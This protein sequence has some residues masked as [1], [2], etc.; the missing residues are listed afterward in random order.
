MEK[1]VITGGHKLKGTIKVSGAKNAALPLL[2][3]TILNDKPVQ[4]N[5]VPHLVDITTTLKILRHMGLSVQE[6]G[7]TIVV[8]GKTV[9]T[10][11]APYDLVRTMRASVLALGPLV[12]RF[13]QGKVSLPGGCSIG[14]RPV[15]LHL[16]AL[17]K[18]GASIEIIEGYIH[19]KAAKLQGARI[20]FPIISVGATENTLM[21]ATLAKG[22]TLIENAAQ[23]PEIVDLANLLIA[24]G[25]PIEGAGTS[26]IKVQGVTQLKACTHSVIA[27]RIETGTYLAAVAIAGGSIRLQGVSESLLSAVTDKFR[28]AGVEI[29]EEKSAAGGYDLLVKY[30]ESKMGPLKSV[31]I[32]TKEFPGFP[33]DMQAQLMAAMCFANGTSVISETI[34]ENRFMHVPELNRLGADIAIHGNTAKVTGKGQNGLS[35]ATVMATDLRASACLVLAGLGAKG[36]TVVRRIYHLDRGYERMEEKLRSI[37]AHIV[38]EQENN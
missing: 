30:D 17:E 21:A 19:A 33:T 2:F 27:D 34:F 11:E 5:N 31:D 25:V 8:D 28:E 36:T 29:K 35:G 26:K 7:D 13:G 32:I 23:E 20:T 15:D 18:M 10:L 24:M 14:A 22:E 16:M 6:N 1:L 38:R 3:A 37:G 4:L 9:S 12:A